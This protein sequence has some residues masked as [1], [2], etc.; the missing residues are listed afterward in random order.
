MRKL[1][2]PRTRTGAGRVHSRGFT[3]TEELSKVIESCG[4]DFRLW[5]HCRDSDRL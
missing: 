2:N 1:L 4:V 5:G 3:F